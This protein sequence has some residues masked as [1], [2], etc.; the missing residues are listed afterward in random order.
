MIQV[1]MHHVLNRRRDHPGHVSI[2]PGTLGDEPH[3]AQGVQRRLSLKKRPPHRPMQ[4]RDVE[5]SMLQADEQHGSQSQGEGPQH[6]E[7]QGVAVN[8]PKGS[9]TRPLQAQGP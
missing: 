9:L 4:V 2:G 7:A 8:H 3:G 5:H 1:S 6:V